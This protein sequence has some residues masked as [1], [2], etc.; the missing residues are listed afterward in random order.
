MGIEMKDSGVKWI[1]EIPKDWGVKK[2]K[3]VA[4]I[5]LL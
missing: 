4:E 3:F 1:G 5:L 2:L